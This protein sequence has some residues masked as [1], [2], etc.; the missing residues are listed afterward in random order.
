MAA[1]NE[2]MQK[3][4]DERIRVRA[5]QF[6]KI[7]IAISDD[8]TASVEV[9]ARAASGEA[10]TD[11]RKDGPPKLLDSAD[12]LAFDAVISALLK[13]AAGAATVDD[14]KAMN[15]GWPIFQRACV[16]PVG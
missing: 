3:F 10:W 14:I 5:E 15:D 12:F 8:K 1:T 7:L 6:R 16:Q 13:C 9:L 4:A 2:Q 11:D